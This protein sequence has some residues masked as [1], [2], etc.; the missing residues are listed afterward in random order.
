MS[1]K[2]VGT[3]LDGKWLVI[4]GK[5]D[6]ERQHTFFVLKNEFNGMEIEINDEMLKK[7]VDGKSSV[8]R[9]V[10]FRIKCQRR[11]KDMGVWLNVN[12]KGTE[13]SQKGN[14]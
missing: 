1:S 6:E 9:V 11:G 13:R 12:K 3:V 7:I 5:Y 10:A 8:S 14:N 2:Y 4:S